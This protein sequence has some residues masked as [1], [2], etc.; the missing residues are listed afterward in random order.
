MKGARR[1]V[2]ARKPGVAAGIRAEHV[3]VGKNVI[4]T[5]LGNRFAVR[6]H[7]ARIGTDLGLGE[8][9][10]QAHPPMLRGIRS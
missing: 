10:A 1:R 2:G 6:T 3:V 9:H 4:E 8:D 7:S 5:K